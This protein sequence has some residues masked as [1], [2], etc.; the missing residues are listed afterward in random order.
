MELSVIIVTWNVREDIL[1]CLNSIRENP[2]RDECEIIVIDNASNDGT[3]NAVRRR[4]PDIRLISNDKNRGFAGANNQGFAKAAGRYVFFLNPDTVVRPG[5]FDVLLDFMEDRPDVGACGPRLVFEDGRIQKT[6]RCFPTFA[7]TLHRHT[8]FKTL[9]IFRPAYNKWL[10]KDFTY[11]R[12]ADVDQIMGAALM[13]RRNVLEDV[14]P[15][16]EQN[17]FMYYEE[18]DLCYR[19]KKAGLRIVF[20]PDAEIIH[21]G[22]RSSKQIPV[23]KTIM[24]MKSLL[25]F[26]KKY[27][28]PV[29]YTLFRWLFKPVFV[30]NEIGNL[31]IY[32]IAYTFGFVC[33]SSKIRGYSVEKLKYSTKLLKLSWQQGLG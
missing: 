21:L 7:G 8:I 26:F 12:T 16:D 27:R 28:S 11:D 17:F 31:F 25:R 9:G 15:M 19:I 32:A 22:G 20:V 3:A 30:L 5:S 23:E 10:M 13:V 2:P 24:A 18:V 4:F 33:L 14:G 29:S 1:R 6:V